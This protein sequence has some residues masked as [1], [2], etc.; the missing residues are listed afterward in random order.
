MSTNVRTSSITRGASVM[1]DD[2]AGSGFSLVDM[3]KEIKTHLSLVMG[4]SLMLGLY[5]SKGYLVALIDHE[6]SEITVQG[7]LRQLSSGDVSS[8]VSPWLESSF[9]TADLEEIKAEVDSLPWVYRSTV[10][11][12]WPGRITI[13]AT[14]QTPIASWNGDSYLN[15]AGGVFTPEAL[16]WNAQ[17]PALIGPADSSLATKTEMITRLSELEL[18][19][20]SH[21]LSL[22]SLELKAR[23]VWELQL[24]DGIRVAL[25][26]P[27]FEGKVERI[28]AVLDGAAL[29]TRQ[30]MQAIDTRY[31]NGLAIKWKDPAVKPE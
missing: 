17:L 24:T 20:A 14:E 12:V 2:A 26:A 10:S 16:T 28:A 4:L 11:R 18:L 30:R 29:D 1:R 13:N 3:L 15:A 7:E 8:K 23:G 6:I 21:Q 31:P 9:L 5:L 25:G 22:R 19:L 27:P